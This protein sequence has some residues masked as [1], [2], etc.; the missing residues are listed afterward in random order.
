[1][2]PYRVVST[3]TGLVIIA[4]LALIAGGLIW[5]QNELA[6]TEDTIYSLRSQDLQQ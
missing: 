6:E 3:V 4:A 5:W 2:N 1:M